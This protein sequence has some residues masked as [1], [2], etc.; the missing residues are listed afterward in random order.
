MP[1]GFP[2][3]TK[4]RQNANISIR[5]KSNNNSLALGINSYDYQ[6]NRKIPPLFFRNSSDIVIPDLAIFTNSIWAKQSPTDRFE[7]SFQ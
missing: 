3:I 4:Y 2:L 1:W 7:I 6:K 5:L